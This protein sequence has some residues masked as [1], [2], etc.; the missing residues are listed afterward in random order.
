M[1][2]NIRQEKEKDFQEVFDLTKKAFANLE[3]SDH[4]E[5]FLVEHLR[6]SKNFIPELSL[7]AEI[8]GK[9]AGHILLTK[10]N[11]IGKDKQTE[12]LI[13][14]PVSVLPEYQKQGIGS[15][16][17]LAAHAKAKELGYSS[18]ILTGHA[19]YYPRFGYKKLSGFGVSVPFEAPDECCL[20]VELEEGALSDAAGI[21]EFPP[22]FTAASSPK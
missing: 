3:V 16:L 7:V 19:D 15:K 13:L 6:L 20:G 4:T 8:N 11:I 22:E 1:D 9:I 12:T 5:Q 2:V 14:A 18:V 17:I 21:V 10:I